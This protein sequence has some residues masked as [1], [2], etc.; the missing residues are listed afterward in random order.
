MPALKRMLA[1]RK[2]LEKQFAE[3]KVTLIK[4]DGASHGP[5]EPPEELRRAGARRKHE[6]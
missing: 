5:E 2:I 4:L 6:P 3:R 1:E